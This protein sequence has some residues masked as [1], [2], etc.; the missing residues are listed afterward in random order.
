MVTW[1]RSK[2]PNRQNKKLQSI[3]LCI[4]ENENVA[5]PRFAQQAITHEPV[6]PLE[7]LAHIGSSR[8]Q[9]NA[10]GR[11]KTEH[12]LHPLQD[13]YQPLQRGYIETSM[14]FDLAPTLECHHYSAAV[15]GQALV[16]S[17]QLHGQ[18]LSARPVALVLHTLFSKI[19]IER[20]SR[21]TSRATEIAP[22]HA[23]GSKL[24]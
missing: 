14:N 1:H 15:A 12:G 7:G 9:I 6:Q 11:T 10:G 5:A 21:D 24:G 13:A 4:T 22:L 19:A 16:R 18:Q 20:A 17:F 8:R 2:A 3:A 23:A